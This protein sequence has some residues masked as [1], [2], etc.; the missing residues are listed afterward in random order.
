MSN[1]V[2]AK[3]Q[4]RMSKII[5]FSVVI[6]ILIVCVIAYLHVEI[7]EEGIMTSAEIKKARLK[8]IEIT[9]SND[10]EDQKVQRL[11]DLAKEIGAG[12]IHTEQ[13]EGTV[14]NGALSKPQN[15]ISESELVQNIHQALQTAMTLNMCKTANKQYKIAVLAAIVAV[16]STFITWNVSIKKK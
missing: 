15:P 3:K 12:T 10:P 5:I 4:E 7:K 13:V 11:K 2:I 9:D 6:I 8:L 14:Y 1:A 16:V